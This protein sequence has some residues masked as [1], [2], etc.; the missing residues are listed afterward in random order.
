MCVIQDFQPVSTYHYLKLCVCLTNEA[1]IHMPRIG[2]Q[3]ASDRSEWYAVERILRKHAAMY[4]V[5]IY[6]YATLSPSMQFFSCLVNY[7]ACL[8]IIFE[9]GYIM[10]KILASVSEHY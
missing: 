4:C 2:Y 3:D 10:L 8:I 9:E 7:H 6:V 5:K 1:S